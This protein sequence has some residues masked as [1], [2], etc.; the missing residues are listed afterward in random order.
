MLIGS[1]CSRFLAM[2]A[3]AT[4]HDISDFPGKQLSKQD[5]GELARAIHELGYHLHWLQEWGKKRRPSLNIYKTTI[6][7]HKGYHFLEQAKYEAPI[8]FQN[9]TFEDF[10]GQIGG[11]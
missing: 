2:D 10:A 5:Y 3:L 7:N 6:K 4:L 8:N 1:L 9:M 11:G